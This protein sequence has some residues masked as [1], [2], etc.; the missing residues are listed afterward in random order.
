MRHVATTQKR[1]TMTVFVT[2]VFLLMLLALTI[3]V[4]QLSQTKTASAVDKSS[5]IAGNIISDEEFTAN[6]SMSVSDIQYFL[7]KKLT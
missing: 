2:G 5:W 6:D 7:D 3:T 4:M 1:T